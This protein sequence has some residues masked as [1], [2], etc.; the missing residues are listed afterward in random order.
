MLKPLSDHDV[1]LMLGMLAAFLA[2][3]RL[4]GEA[5]TR[6]R[7]P[8]VL[9]E[10]IAGVLLGPSL[11]GLASGTALHVAQRGAQILGPLSWM[12][13]ILLLALTGIETNFAALRRRA[14]A[15]VLTTAGGI[16]LPLAAGFALG[17]FLPQ[18]LVGQAGSRLAFA[19]FL[20]LAMSISA[21]TV[22]AKVLADLQQ[23]RRTAAQII[24]T[25]GV[26]DETAGWIL[27]AL[28]SGLVGTHP[29]AGA[30]LV[31]VA[32]AA[33]FLAGAALFGRRV[34]AGIVRFVR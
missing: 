30:T 20:A 3:A 34:V 23:M 19:L 25:G 11:L 27:L 5:A 29:G 24:L 14:G 7:Q 16:A 26:F 2:F 12:G 31:V 13:I 15:A 8:Q 10:L 28:V 22:I 32:K 17:W 21:V 18:G 6:L 4:C 9:G 33:A 1:L